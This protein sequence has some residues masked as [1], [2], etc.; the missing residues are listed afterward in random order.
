MDRNNDK[1]RS[2]KVRNIIGDIPTSLT[3]CAIIINVIIFLA[4]ICAAI[5]ITYPY[6]NNEES[7]LFHII[8]AI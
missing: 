7:L 6:T 8:H 4:L 1:I 2:E 3:Q 5:F